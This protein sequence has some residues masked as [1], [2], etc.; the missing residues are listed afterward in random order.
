MSSSWRVIL[1]GLL[2]AGA[3]W[4]FALSEAN[5]STR[6]VPEWHVNTEAGF[7]IR[8]P[9]GWVNRADDRE[10]TQIAPAKQPSSGFATLIV[11]TRLARDESPMPYLT[12]VV[13]RPPAGPIRD[14]K[15]LRQEKISMADGGE[16]ALGEFP[17]IYRG[18]PVHG[19][20]VFSIRQGKLLQAVVQ[21]PADRADRVED[22]MIQSLKSVRPL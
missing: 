3:L 17:E 12:D 10:G 13:A 15:W 14:L 11:S 5:K 1:S 16:G 18:L 4:V 21:V 20:M 7:R 2:L 19:W 22:A 9:A 6:D 8:P